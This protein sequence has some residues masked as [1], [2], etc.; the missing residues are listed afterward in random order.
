MIPGT[1]YTDSKTGITVTLPGDGSGL[2]AGR[3]PYQDLIYLAKDL[4]VSGVDLDYEEMWHADYFKV[5]APAAAPG[6]NVNITGNLSYCIAV[7]LSL[8]QNS[9]LMVPESSS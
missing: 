1:L 6:T 9:L 3:N 2:K 4:G 8:H 5:D 7:T